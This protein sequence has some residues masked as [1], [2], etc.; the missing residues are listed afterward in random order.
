VAADSGSDLNAALARLQQ[1]S[2]DK[3]KAL[4]A[5]IRVLRSSLGICQVRVSRRGIWGFGRVESVRFV[6]GTHSYRL[7][8]VGGKLE[9]A[10]GDAIGGVGLTPEVVAYEEWVRSLT[11]EIDDIAR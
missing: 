1:S 10:I 3:R 7:T 6:V 11:Y 8:L 5:L 2:A 4:D 9:A